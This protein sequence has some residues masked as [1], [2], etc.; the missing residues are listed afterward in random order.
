MTWDSSPDLSEPTPVGRAGLETYPTSAYNAHMTS[1]V[2]HPIHARE[3]LILAPYAQ[4]SA[5]SRGRKHPEDEHPY[6]GPFQRDRDRIVH[7]AAFR[8]LADKTQVFTSLS[9]YHRT[10]LTHTM[11]VASIARTISRA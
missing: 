4:F 9:D 3:K 7:S 1:A 6:R 5:N 8:R 11:E 10:R 2:A